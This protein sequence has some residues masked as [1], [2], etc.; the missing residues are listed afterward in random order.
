MGADRNDYYQNDQDTYDYSSSRMG[1]R[2]DRDSNFDYEAEDR[3]YRGAG[4][5]P[6]E[7]YNDRSRGADEE[8]ERNYSPQRRNRQLDEDM[9]RERGEDFRDRGEDFYD[10]NFQGTRNNGRSNYRPS[11]GGGD[12]YR[13]IDTDRDY[14]R[15]LD[16]DRGGM[17][18]DRYERMNWGND[19]YGNSRTRDADYRDERFERSRDQYHD[20]EEIRPRESF[21]GRDDFRSQ[22]EEGYRNEQRTHDNLSGIS[23]GYG[24]NSTRESIRRG[25]SRR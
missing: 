2:S 17:N 4:R 18:D 1:M 10:R 25:G 12:L 22:D 6:D 9:S 24:G 14:D 19:S 7:Y 20:R 23:G 21:I 11:G 15:N 3:S 5:Q 13:D 8:R 16:R